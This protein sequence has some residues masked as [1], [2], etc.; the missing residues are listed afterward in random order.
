MAD[1]ES[2]YVTCNDEVVERR[3]RTGLL[4]LILI[5]ENAKYWQLQHTLSFL[6]LKGF[7]ISFCNAFEKLNSI[8]IWEIQQLSL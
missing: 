5:K 3:E 2:Y 8:V 1:S 7:N 6:T 4:N